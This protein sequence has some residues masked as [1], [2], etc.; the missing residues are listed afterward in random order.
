M[1]HGKQMVFAK[2]EVEAITVAE[3]GSVIQA[4]IVLR[5]RRI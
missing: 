1:I 3:D 2:T 5:C 4:Q